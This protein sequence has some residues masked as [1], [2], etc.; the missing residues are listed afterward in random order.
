MGGSGGSIEPPKIFKV[1][2]NK[3]EE[4]TK[5]GKRKER[6]RRETEEKSDLLGF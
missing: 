6:E 2:K 4:K 1:K 3:G 5:E